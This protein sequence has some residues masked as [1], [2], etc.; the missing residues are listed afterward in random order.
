MS[1]PFHALDEFLSLPRTT[2]LW[3]APDGARLVVAVDQQDRAG[4][5]FV[6]S[7]W[8]VDPTGAAPVRRL[9]QGRT[10]EVAAGFL[11]D[12]SV[13]FVAER[14]DPEVVDDPDDDHRKSVWV[15]PAAG[16]EA[17]RVADLPGGVTG[18]AVAREAGTLVVAGPVFPGA[19]DAE[20]DAARRTARKDKA[21]RAILHES[22]SVRHWD[23]DLGPD[24]P[25]LFAVADDGLRD[26]TPDAGRALDDAAF[27]VSSDGRTVV[28]TWRVPV[29]DG[30]RRVDLVAVD[31]ATGQRRVLATDP[32]CNHLEPRISADGRWVV[33]VKAR[34]STT[35]EPPDL[36]LWLQPL[37][38]A[39]PARDLTPELDLWPIAPR[40]APDGRTVYFTADETGRSPLFAVTVATGAVQRLAGDA[41]YTA[42]SAPDGPW[43]YA[44]RSA[45]DAP[46][47][48]VRLAPDLVDQEPV[49]LRGVREAPALPG[50][51]TEVQ[52]EAGDGTPLRA[53][54][55]L[56]E[57]QH[58][59]PLVLW[60]HGGPLYSWNAWMWRWNPW[61]LAARGYAVLMP[62]PALSTGYGQEFIC[63][64]W[65][66]WGNEPFTDLMTMTD[67]ACARPDIDADRT[68]A[69]GGS[70]G[71]YMANWIATKTTRF[72][73]I[74]SHAGLWDLDAFTATSD[75][76][77]YWAREL[78]EERI[79]L[80]SPHL[81]GGK[82]T[83][84]MLVTHGDR[85]HRVPIGA[86]LRLWDRLWSDHGGD[87]DDFPHRF[88]YYPDENHWVLKPQHSKLWYETV[89]AFLAWHVGGEPWQ[90]PELV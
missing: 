23:H 69:M 6:S 38:D 2:G 12:G 86:A 56:P 17:R 57:Q 49:F 87:P 26:L 9:T 67:A 72:A 5:R 41:T 89:L 10:S 75:M 42:V 55:V 3:S 8:E 46:P 85:D 52:A 60:V 54:L 64:G 47:A 24:E 82:I 30:D 27:D 29:P 43:V 13:V 34:R 44:L 16:G 51:L 36:T 1:S 39:E 90:R 68:A 84:P 20:A 78:T 22:R 45:V 14:A 11:P 48:V 88:L 33:C 50:R 70:F 61:V 73:A 74:V 15:L 81:A 66:R 71:G 19:T 7:L 40:W 65:G 59:A 58:P 76:A 53:W 62:D 77:G 21:V 28:T 32:A 35:D 80:S 63:R 79:A 83:T 25:H 37:D 4:K 18:V 31:V